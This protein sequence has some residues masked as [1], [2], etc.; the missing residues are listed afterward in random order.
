MDW[1]W[2]Y[3]RAILSAT[4]LTQAAGQ[5]GRM[6]TGGGATGT[7]GGQT[8]TSGAR[9]GPVFTFIVAVSLVFAF[10]NATSALMEH[11]N[12]GS[13]IHIWE[14]VLWELSSIVAL[15]ALCPVIFALYRR[16]SPQ[17]LGL[18]RFLMLQL[19]IVIVFSL[20]HVAGMVA[21]RYA[22]YGLAGMH[23]DFGHGH[24]P[25][26]LLYEG[27]KDCLS[28]GIYMGIFWVADRLAVSPPAPVRPQRVEVRTD[29][30][31]LYFEPGEIL[32]VEAAGNYVEL[33]VAGRPSPVLVRGTLAEYEA[34]LGD[35]DFVRIH[36]S[37]L[38]N[39]GHV[40][41]IETTHSGDITVTLSDGRE[42]AGSRRYRE[43]LG[44]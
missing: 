14:P 33:N 24:L 32:W 29:G 20:L 42:I 16:Y 7:D 8:G 5:A 12:G 39:R 13:P 6:G 36:R 17:K 4:G 40:R 25:L 19:P 30:R 35:A 31:V 38:L 1:I 2:R 21:V 34:R 44:Q 28:Y 26:E 11:A 43:A 15:F 23:Y 27:R 10:V 3:H 18:A 37:R 22:G 41:Q 9:F